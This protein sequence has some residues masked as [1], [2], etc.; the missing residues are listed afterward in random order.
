M[1]QEVRHRSLQ[2][3]DR[4]GRLGFPTIINGKRIEPSVRRSQECIHNSTRFNTHIPS[5][6]TNFWE[7]SLTTHLIPLRMHLVQ[8][9]SPGLISHLILCLLHSAPEDVSALPF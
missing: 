9:D 1:A 2:L 8:F 5:S 7:K 3:L 4:G 6:S